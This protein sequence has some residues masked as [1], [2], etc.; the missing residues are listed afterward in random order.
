[1]TDIQL[2]NIDPNQ[3][4]QL[5]ELAAEQGQTVDVYVASLLSDLLRKRT[6]DR[7]KGL[8]SRIAKRFENLGLQDGEIEELRGHRITPP[9]LGQ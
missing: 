1:M 8:G 4:V 2:K 7:E 9:E 6:A 3:F 5:E